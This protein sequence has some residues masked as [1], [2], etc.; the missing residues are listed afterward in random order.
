[1]TRPRHFHPR[2][3]ALGDARG[4]TIV[5]FGIIAPVLCLLLMGAFD[6][7]H[8]LYMQTV[9]QGI[10]QKAARDS[11]LESSDDTVL[12][13]ID[14]TVT[15]EVKALNNRVTP[16][17]SRRYYRTFADASAAKAEPWTDTDKD[18]T[19]D[20]GEPYE[21]DNNNGMWDK[22]GG[23]G[24]QGGAKDRTVYTVTLN[25][26]H[27]FPIYGFIG[28]SNYVTLSATTILENQPYSEQGVY[29][30]PKVLN[31]P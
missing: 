24:G 2:R 8:T 1:M 26:P 4:A 17:F 10:V 7:A 5:E 6:V 28:L 31:C 16:A 3:A 13:D 25:Y 15:A 20:H 29:T 19:C 30:T 23:N 21:D 9:L 27:L 11:T 12:P 18:G 22:D 14:A